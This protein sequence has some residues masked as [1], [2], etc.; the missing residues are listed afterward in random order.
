M[1]AD[2]QHDAITTILYSLRCGQWFAPHTLQ[3][4]CTFVLSYWTLASSTWSLS[5]LCPFLPAWTEHSLLCNTGNECLS[6]QRFSFYYSKYIFKGKLRGENV[7][8]KR[9]LWFR[10]YILFW[11][12]ANVLEREK[13]GKTSTGK[14]SWLSVFVF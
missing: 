14:R 5:S 2:P 11:G 6:K 8:I 13:P 4:C 9:E 12:T 10:L 3:F 7:S 1:K